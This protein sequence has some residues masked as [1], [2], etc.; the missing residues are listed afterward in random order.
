MNKHD[1]Q[2]TMRNPTGAAGATGARQILQTLSP[3][4]LRQTYWDKLG[5]YSQGGAHRV[6][7]RGASYRVSNISSFRSSTLRLPLKDSMNAFCCG[8]PGSMSYQHVHLED[9]FCLG[10]GLVGGFD[11]VCLTRTTAPKAL[12]SVTLDRGGR[13]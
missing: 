7:M 11:R 13:F 3:P 2:S 10:L 8:L 9:G 12:W 5:Q 1:R 6:I 4:H